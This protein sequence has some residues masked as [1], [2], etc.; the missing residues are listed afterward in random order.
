MAKISIRLTRNAAEKSHNHDNL[1]KAALAA[2]EAA[3]RGDIFCVP[4][5]ANGQKFALSSRMIIEVDWLPNRIP[6]KAL[7]DAGIVKPGKP[8]M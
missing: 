7:R 6:A 1:K 3:G 8:R 2:F 5:E 4:F